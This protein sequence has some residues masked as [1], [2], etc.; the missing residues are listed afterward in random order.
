MHIK[1]P[2]VSEPQGHLK[3]RLG[4]AKTAFHEELRKIK[5]VKRKPVDT[6]IEFI[7]KT[8][9]LLLILIR[10]LSCEPLA[11]EWLTID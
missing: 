2:S 6:Q 10:Y 1:H 5:D 8:A 4:T 3:I 7:K 9:L 11:E